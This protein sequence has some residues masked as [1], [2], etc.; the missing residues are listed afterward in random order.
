M[1]SGPRAVATYD[2]KAPGNY[3]AGLGRGAIG[4][5]TRSDIGPARDQ[6]AP[7]MPQFGV[8]PTQMLAG[9]ASSG[10]VQ[11]AAAERA[12]EDQVKQLEST[13]FGTV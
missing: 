12:S 2:G 6:P 4:F 7:D 10:A 9:N 11:R 1:S 3:V 5:T 13:Q 8:Q